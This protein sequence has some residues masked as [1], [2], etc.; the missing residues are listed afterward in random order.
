MTYSKNTITKHWLQKDKK[1]KHELT[2]QEESED[3][4]LPFVIKET[5]AD[6]QKESEG[7][8]FSFSVKETETKL[9][10]LQELA[11]ILQREE[12]P[13]VQ[14][15]C[16]MTCQQIHTDEGSGDGVLSFV[17]KEIEADLQEKSEYEILPLIVQEVQVRSSLVTKI[18]STFE[19]GDRTLTTG[20]KTENWTKKEARKAVDYDAMEKGQ[21]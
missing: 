9:Q 12:V 18:K 10:P 4:V 1:G 14:E 17:V 13:K 5:K 8:V 20:R 16:G 21:S 15:H 2:D 19:F 7:E 6:P 3:G 11:K